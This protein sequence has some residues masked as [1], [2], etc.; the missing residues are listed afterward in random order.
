[1]VFLQDDTDSIV[2]EHAANTY[3]KKWLKRNIINLNL[4]P[5]DIGNCYDNVDKYDQHLMCRDRLGISLRDTNTNEFMMTK[6]S[7]Y[8]YIS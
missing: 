2:L 6:A 7:I 8:Y 4:M 5:H 3:F 1:M